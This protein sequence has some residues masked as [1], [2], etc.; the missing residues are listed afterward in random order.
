MKCI[1]TSILILCACFV[2]VA[3]GQQPAAKGRIGWSEFHRPDM[4]RWNRYEKVLGVN[5]AGR[6]HLKWKYSTSFYVYSSPAVANGV[7]YIGG[8]DNNVYALNASTGA[9]LWTFA[10]GNQVDSSPP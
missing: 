3:W 7:V 1:R 5:N 8:D 10:A 4:V 2:S 9:V 6:L